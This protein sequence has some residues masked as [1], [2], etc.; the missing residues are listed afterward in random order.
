LEL[1]ADVRELTQRD[2]NVPSLS[3]QL[4]DEKRGNWLILHGHDHYYEFHS[5][6]SGC[7][8]V[9][10]RA[11]GLKKPAPIIAKQFYPHNAS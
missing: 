5:M 2:C 8:Q 6:L 3:S 11:Y 7:G 1:T 9:T 10:G 4:V